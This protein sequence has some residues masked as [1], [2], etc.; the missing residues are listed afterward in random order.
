MYKGF[1]KV[2]REDKQCYPVDPATLEA[3]RCSC[4]DPS[5][6]DVR[7]LDNY[8]AVEVISE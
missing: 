7:N 1:I 3:V 6:W 8:E 5:P 4:Y 2:V